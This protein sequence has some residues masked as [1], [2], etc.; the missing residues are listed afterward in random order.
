[1]AFQDSKNLVDTLL[2]TQKKV[3][4]NVVESTKK[5]T[6][7]NNL[8]NET[9]EKGSDWYKNWLETQKNLFNKTTAQAE[10]TTETVKDSSSKMT[11]FYQNW[12][13]T[14]SAFAKQIFEMGQD[15]AKNFTNGSTTNNPFATWQNSFT[16]ASNPFA[17]MSNPFANMS[18]PFTTTNNPFSSWMNNMSNNNWMSQM[19]QANP[20]SNDMLKKST[21]NM[22]AMFTEYT[23]ML[24]KT[25][26]DFQKNF[27]NGTAQDA[28]KGMMSTGEG[29]AKFAEMWMPMFKSIQDKSFNMDAYKQ[30]MNP[31]L[32]KDFMDKFFGFLPENSRKQMHDMQNTITDSLKHMTQGAMGGYNQMR[33]MM[34]NLGGQA[35]AFAGMNDAYNNWNNMMTEAAG[36]FAKMVTPNDQTKAIQEWSEI[37]KR[38]TQYNIKNAELQYMVYNQGTKVMDKLAEN[39]AAKIENGTEVSS[40]LGLYQ[41]W[42]NISDKVYISLFESSAYSELM[43]EVAAMKLRITKDVELQSEKMLKD[44]PVATRSEMDEV[45]KTIYDLKKK[46]KQLEKM[47]ELDG[48]I[49]PEVSAEEKTAKKATAKKA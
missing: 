13:N 32:Y 14:Q 3:V 25:M 27:Q 6:N 36:P 8:I 48:E 40:M 4:E 44:I 2:D 24:G 12:M 9:I 31:E 5:L 22:T 47:L 39:I 34:T 10:T 1:M 20:F 37:S 17:N 15:S 45:Y 35:Q 19:Q 38:V 30:M 28:F 18:N 49:K 46:V 23:N 26:G 16:N 43:A 33:G 41:E 7:G 29:F 11:E 21:D 42:L